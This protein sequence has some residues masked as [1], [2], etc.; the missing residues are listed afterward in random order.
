MTNRRPPSVAMSTHLMHAV[1]ATWPKNQLKINKV[2]FLYHHKIILHISTATTCNSM[3]NHQSNRYILRPVVASFS[4]LCTVCFF[5]IELTHPSDHAHFICIPN[6][7][8]CS[9]F[10]GLVKEMRKKE[11]L[12]SA[13]LYTLYISKHSGMDHTVLSANTPCLPFLRKHTPDGAA[14]FKMGHVKG[15]LS[16]LCWELIQ[17]TCVQSLITLA[18]TVPEI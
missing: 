10:I 9:T 14:K 7:N 6:F 3:L 2:G 15:D 17:L 4:K 12:Y 8:E 13:I 11:Y 5:Q 18:S 1:H 16:S